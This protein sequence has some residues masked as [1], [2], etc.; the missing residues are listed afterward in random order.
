[1]KSKR[2][3]AWLCAVAVSGSVLGAAFAAEPEDVI[4]YRKSMMKA[5]A[6]HMGAA[7]AIINGKVD[8]KSDLANHGKALA[9]LMHDV[10][11][12][13]PKDSD[14][15]ETD[16]LDAVWKK[17]ADF[18]KLSDNVR[19][20]SAAFAKAASGGDKAKV[21]AAFKELNEACKA[22]HKDFRKEKH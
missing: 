11:G 16:A 6:G 1:M 7:A 3:A 2:I 10:N 13:F 8:Y 19:S 15:G 12:L 17:P 14:F 4:K 18:K 21:G 20:K 9:A 5:T 22:C